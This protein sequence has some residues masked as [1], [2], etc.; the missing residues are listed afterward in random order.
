MS[1]ETQ[2]KLFE[3]SKKWQSDL[4]ELELDATQALSF[5]IMFLSNAVVDN[6]P[7]SKDEEFV[8]LFC[9]GLNESRNIATKK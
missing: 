5:L 6:V 1:D 4:I 9:R 7:S 8:R 2:R 3:L